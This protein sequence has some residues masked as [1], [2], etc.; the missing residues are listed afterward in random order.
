MIV[1]WLVMVVRRWDKTPAPKVVFITGLLPRYEV[2]PLPWV[3]L[4]SDILVVVEQVD[5]AWVRVMNG[6]PMVR[7]A[8]GPRTRTH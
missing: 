1:A 6:N 2:R 8:F 7:A 4:T 5:L 3:S